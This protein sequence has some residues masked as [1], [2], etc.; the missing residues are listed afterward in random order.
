VP[1]DPHP[2]V[3]GTPS[4]K[5]DVMSQGTPDMGIK[6]TD[7]KELLQLVRTLALCIPDTSDR[8]VYFP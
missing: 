1:G 4:T 6:G 5:N 3:Y 7:K 2:Y 8:H